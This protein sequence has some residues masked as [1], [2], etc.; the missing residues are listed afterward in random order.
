ME[1]SVK[2]YFGERGNVNAIFNFYDYVSAKQ[3]YDSIILNSTNEGKAL[4]EIEDE[5]EDLIESE[6][7]K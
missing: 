6:I 5:E 7:N 3:C 2:K 1:Y 4:Y